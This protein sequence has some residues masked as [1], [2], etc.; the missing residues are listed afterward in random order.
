MKENHYLNKSL[1][2]LRSLKFGYT[3]KILALRND[4]IK[5]FV[6]KYSIIYCASV[7]TTGTQ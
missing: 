5:I 4:K 3:E 7:Y 6:S 1:V 2:L